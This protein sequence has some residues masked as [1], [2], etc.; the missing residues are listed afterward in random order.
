MI[1]YNQYITEISPSTVTGLLGLGG[2]GYMLGN[3]MTSNDAGTTT[4]PSNPVGYLGD[5]AGK[6]KEWWD[7]PGIFSAL[8]TER[9]LKIHISIATLV[10][11]F[12][13]IFKISKLEWFICL[14]CIMTVISSELINTAIETTIDIAM[15]NKNELAKRAKDIAASSVLI[16]AI[17]SAIICLIIFVPKIIMLFK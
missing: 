7:K 12:G 15:P 3:Q 17:I 10:I 6:L 1:T 9:N 5:Q 14:I 11:I 13:I 4:M 2:A 8:K 16:L